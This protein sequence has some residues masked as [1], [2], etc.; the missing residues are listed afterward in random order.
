MARHEYFL[1]RTRQTYTPAL[2]VPDT[3]LYLA[4]DCDEGKYY[5]GD[6]DCGDEL[7]LF[8]LLLSK[9]ISSND[10]AFAKAGALLGQL[11][12]T[13]VSGSDLLP[14]SLVYYTILTSSMMGSKG[15]LANF[16]QQSTIATSRGYDHRELV[17]SPRFTRKSSYRSFSLVWEWREP[18][19]EELRKLD[20]CVGVLES[21]AS[22]GKLHDLVVE[23]TTQSIDGLSRDEIEQLAKNLRGY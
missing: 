19:T 11:W 2:T 12:F 21:E 4:N 22:M 15:S 13:P 6:L 9:R 17:W 8:V 23:A 3:P 14:E 10:Y 18:T 16:V 1:N 7:Q 5:L 20:A